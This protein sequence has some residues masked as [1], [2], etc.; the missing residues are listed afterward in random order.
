MYYI[1]NLPKLQKIIRLSRDCKEVKARLVK[2]GE[3]CFNLN[4]YEVTGPKAYNTESVLPFC[5]RTCIE[6]R[7]KE[8]KEQK[9]PKDQKTAYMLLGFLD[10]DTY[11]IHE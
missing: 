3:K 7:E 10:E 1:V 5:N 11:S 6:M 8:P 4:N 2:L 9:D